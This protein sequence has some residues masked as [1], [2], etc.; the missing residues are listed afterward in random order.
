M[1]FVEIQHGVV[2]FGERAQGGDIGAVA[3]HAE[4]RFGDDEGRAALA[5]RGQQFVK[6]V[7]GHCGETGFA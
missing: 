6:M 1:R 5:M 4:D 3:V 7:R 2:A